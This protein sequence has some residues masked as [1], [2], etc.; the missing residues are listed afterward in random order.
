MLGHWRGRRPKGAQPS[1]RAH[2]TASSRG[3]RPGAGG[4]CLPGVSPPAS[5]SQVREDPRGCLLGSGRAGDAGLGRGCRA[6]D[7]RLWPAAL[8][9]EAGALVGQLGR[10][11]GE[12]GG[13]HRG[14]VGATEGGWAPTTERVAPPME[15]PPAQPAHLSCSAPPLPRGRQPPLGLENPGLG[16]PGDV[17]PPGNPSFPGSSSDPQTCPPAEP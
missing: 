16:Y 12:V 14:W 10:A 7:R 11:G 1:G 8:Y 15:R 5:P 17:H 3:Q 2:V 13:G 9:L 6:S 4:G